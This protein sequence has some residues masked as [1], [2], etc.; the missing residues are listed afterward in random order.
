MLQYL[1]IFFN[2]Q[3]GGGVTDPQP[4]SLNIESHCC[5]DITLDSLATE[6]L[7]RAVPC[8]VA[9]PSGRFFVYPAHVEH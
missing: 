9:Q 6:L 2:L 8:T 3:A 4:S 5:V 1:T 7:T